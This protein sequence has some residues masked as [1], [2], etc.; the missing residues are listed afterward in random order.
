MAETLDPRKDPEV[1]YQV[2]RW[3]ASQI[4]RFQ[5][6]IEEE[7]LSL[8]FTGITL[9]DLMLV[10]R[11]GPN[12]VEIHFEGKPIRRFELNFVDDWK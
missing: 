4:D 7:I 11:D 5:E 10:Y 6:M 2:E 8:L 12:T 1:L 3:V 9:K